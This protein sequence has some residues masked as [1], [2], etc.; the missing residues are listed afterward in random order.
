MALVFWITAIAFLAADTTDKTPGYVFVVLGMICF[1]PV[2]LL[3]K[4][5]DNRQNQEIVHPS[6]VKQ[7]LA[8][9]QPVHDINKPSDSPTDSKRLQNDLAELTRQ[10]DKIKVA[11][12]DLTNTQLALCEVYELLTGGMMNG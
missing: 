10:A 9:N 4:K 2:L 3:R 12:E 7:P 1:L 8:K 5:K 6:P 11:E